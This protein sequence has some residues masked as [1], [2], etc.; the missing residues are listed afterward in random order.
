ML[1]RHNGTGS[2]DI[3]GVWWE[4]LDV[5]GIVTSF[6]KLDILSKYYV[7]RLIWVVELELY[8]GHGAHCRDVDKA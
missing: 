3:R 5:E 8:V 4:T 1:D 2:A 7:G 6:V